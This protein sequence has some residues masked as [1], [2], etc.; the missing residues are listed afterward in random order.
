MP[1][2]SKKQHCLQY[3]ICTRRHYKHCR[4]CQFTYTVNSAI[5]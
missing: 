1:K 5:L 3:Q 4:K 2:Y